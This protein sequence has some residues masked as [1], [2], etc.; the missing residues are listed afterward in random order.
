VPLHLSHSRHPIS[1]AERRLEYPRDVESEFSD[2]QE[3][4]SQYRTAYCPPNDSRDDRK[5]WCRGGGGALEYA[6]SLKAGHSDL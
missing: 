4:A 3:R 5:Q 2:R 6:R 1:Q